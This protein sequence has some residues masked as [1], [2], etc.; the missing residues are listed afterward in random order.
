[1]P[2]LLTWKL[3]RS[4]PEPA[5]S[6]ALA[7]EKPILDFANKLLQ[8]L[9]GGVDEQ[10]SRLAEYRPLNPQLRA[11]G[12]RRPQRTGKAQHPGDAKDNFLL[13]SWHGGTQSPLR[14][15]SF[16]R[17]SDKVFIS[18]ASSSDAQAEPRAPSQPGWRWEP[19]PKGPSAAATFTRHTVSERCCK[20]LF[21]TRPLLHSS[22]SHA[23]AFK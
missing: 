13:L 14:G 19:S 11:D 5:L 17:G 22:S 3:E 10:G 6:H 7:V 8:L 16:Q 4:P 15:R 23:D 12:C 9:A 21:L 2:L 20:G 18:R 1:M